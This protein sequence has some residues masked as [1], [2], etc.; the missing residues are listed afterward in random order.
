[1]SNKILVTGGGGYIG[2]HC[3]VELIKDGFDVV[4]GDNWVNSNRGCFS[5]EL[6]VI[7]FY[8]FKFLLTN[9]CFT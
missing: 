1:M 9:L 4:V 2:S 6:K 8:Q 3:V 7:S 5:S